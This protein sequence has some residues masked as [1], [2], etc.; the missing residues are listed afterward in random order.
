MAGSTPDGWVFTVDDQDIHILLPCECVVVDA[1]CITP[2]TTG[3]LFSDTL[4]AIGYI[5][6][7]HYISNNPENI[8][9]GDPCIINI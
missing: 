1:N 8:H 2:D 5:T 9:I 6:M 7:C 3:K 4:F